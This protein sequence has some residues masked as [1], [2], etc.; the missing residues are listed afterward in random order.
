M[1]RVISFDED[2]AGKFA[3]AGAACD[4]R[5]QLKGAL[6]GAEIGKRET[7]IGGD[8][9]YESDALKIVALGDHLRAD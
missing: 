7:Q 3:T 8:D 5:E 9:S 4:L 2:F 1:L 6:G